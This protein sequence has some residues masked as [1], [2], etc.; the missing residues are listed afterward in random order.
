M[1]LLYHVVKSFNAN[2]NMFDKCVSLQKNDLCWLCCYLAINV[3]LCFCSQNGTNGKFWLEIL[4]MS[5]WYMVYNNILTN[6]DYF[7]VHFYE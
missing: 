7:H 3:I 5:T 4:I 6:V 2:F 1:V